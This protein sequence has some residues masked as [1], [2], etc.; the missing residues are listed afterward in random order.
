DRASVYTCETAHTKSTLSFET[1]LSLHAIDHLRS[2]RCAAEEGQMLNKTI[3]VAGVLTGLTLTATA[4]AEPTADANNDSEGE[5]HQEL[6]ESIQD[7]GSITFGGH[8]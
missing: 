8:V 4:C 5:L 7:A 3:A 2:D 6:P 1:R